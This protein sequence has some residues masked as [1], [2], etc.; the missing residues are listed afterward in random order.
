MRRCDIQGI[1]QVC[2]RCGHIWTPRQEKIRVCPKCKSPYFDVPK[3]K[4]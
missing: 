1:K 2:F 3:R 4:K